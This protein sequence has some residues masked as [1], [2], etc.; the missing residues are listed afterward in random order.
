MT[1]DSILGTGSTHV[2]ARRTSENRVGVVH[3]HLTIYIPAR[4]SLLKL[5]IKSIHFKTSA[6]SEFS[7]F[8]S[9]A[10]VTVRFQILASI[11]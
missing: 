2:L 8:E 6:T 10:K 5:H 4:S 7:F 3:E 1:A 11:S 9:T